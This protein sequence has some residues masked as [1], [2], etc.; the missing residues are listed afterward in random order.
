[1]ALQPQHPTAAGT[2][3]AGKRN[4]QWD[5]LQDYLAPTH[6]QTN[7]QPP[8]TSMMAVSPFESPL[9]VSSAGSPCSSRDFGEQDSP[10]VPYD[11][12]SLFAMD[13]AT[14]ADAP[15][16]TPSNE[17]E[18]PLHYSQPNGDFGVTPSPDQQ[19][20]LYH[21]VQQQHHNR[22]QQMLASQHTSK[23]STDFTGD[24]L[25]TSSG[26][27][28]TNEVNMA[29]AAPS[30]IS[31][32]TTFTPGQRTI[33]LS[34]T[35]TGSDA[36][37]DARTLSLSDSVSSSSQ[38][39]GDVTKPWACTL[40]SSQPACTASSEAPTP[41]SSQES[42]FGDSTGPV[43]ISQLASVF[44]REYARNRETQDT[45]D[46]LNALKQAGIP[47]SQS[48]LTDLEIGQENDD[49][50]TPG[51]STSAEREVATS[52]TVEFALQYAQRTGTE[53]PE[54]PNKT[55]SS[56]NISAKQHLV[57]TKPAS[58]SPT[59]DTS[60][61]YSNSDVVWV[62][63]KRLFCCDVCHKTF[64]RAFNMKTHRTIHESHREYPFAC[65]FAECG[66]AFSRK[67]DCNRHTR[68]VHLKKGERLP[69][70]RSLAIR[71]TG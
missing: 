69:A 20:D 34:N 65:P 4:V 31:P 61:N 8:I 59:G 32:A 52:P 18:S 27:F 43:D 1:M 19:L 12:D 70:G 68:T 21:L 46:L 51:D 45:S 25:M 15:L 37:S 71:G 24:F 13:Q 67:A 60:N 58:L 55:R 40:L 22:H 16:F 2:A 28:N 5:V 10:L 17:D 49:G 44:V 64:D 56:S 53:S 47:V 7:P 3:R 36:G 14:L 33:A 63:G 41:A 26:L 54:A 50:A 6:N 57:P 48:I 30:D 11:D 23:Q 39:G 29:F 62:N 9:G 66:K 35:M 38:E 42:N